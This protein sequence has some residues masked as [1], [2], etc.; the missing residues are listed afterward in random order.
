MKPKSA[1]VPASAPL[2][3]HDTGDDED[4]DDERQKGVGSSKGLSFS[5]SSVVNS[6]VPFARTSTK[7][8]RAFSMVG[9]FIWNGLHSQLR[10][11]PT[12]LSPAF[13]SHLKTALLGRAGVGSASE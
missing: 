11:F 6:L 4:D 10:I 13:F 9:P 12:A 8:S 3:S 1:F 7:Q 5:S 2:L